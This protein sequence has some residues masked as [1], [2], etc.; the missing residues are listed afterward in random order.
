MKDLILIGGGGHCISLIDVAESA[1]YNI[2][3][4]LDLPKNVGKTVLGKTVIGEDDS[5]CDYINTAMFIISLGFINN[6]IIRIK[7]YERIKSIGGRFATIIASTAYVSKYAKIEEGT[8]VLHHANI[9][10][11]AHVGKNCII[12]TFAN[13][14]H[15][16]TIGDYSHIS[17][18]A[19]INGDCKVGSS[20]FIGSQSVL[21]QG[22]E[23]A[24]NSIISAGSFV[25]QN[26]NIQGTYMGNPAHKIK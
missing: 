9:N 8:V 16:C 25:N 22:I 14:E 10:A 12:N 17:T 7:L 6:N 20:V 15:G 19:M 24:D 4:I 26:I 3:G 21:K 13:I 18:G 23:I 1:G 5:A 2:I 11:E